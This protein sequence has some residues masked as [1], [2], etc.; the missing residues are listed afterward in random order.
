MAAGGS[1]PYIE[2]VVGRPY[3]EFGVLI[4]IGAMPHIDIVDGIGVFIAPPPPPPPAPN[5]IEET[6]EALGRLL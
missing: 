6:L 1:I 2:G 3:I 4:G 5:C